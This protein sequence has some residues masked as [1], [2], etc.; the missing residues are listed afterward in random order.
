MT[1]VEDRPLRSDAARNVERILRA[2][3]EVYAELGPDAPVEAVARRAGVGERTLYRRFPAKADLVR[4]ALDQS[5]AEDLTPVI[6]SARHAK[7]PLHGLTR[8]VEAAISLGA[9]EQNL[10]AAAHRAGSLTS[11]IS[12]SLNE[13]LGELVREGQRAGRIRADLVADDLPRLVAMLYSVLSTMDAGSEGWRRYVALVV[14]AISVDER[15]PLPPAAALRYA[16]QPNSWP[17]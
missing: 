4:A 12:V 16:S 6:D 11:D 13:A 2:A 17:L 5:I 3:R 10:L 7:D 1:A 9:R 14:D 15:R 8:L